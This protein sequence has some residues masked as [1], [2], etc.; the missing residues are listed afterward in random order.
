MS[1]AVR[2]LDRLGRLIAWFL[3]KPVRHYEPYAASNMETLRR[4]LM[5]GDVIL[6]DGDERL[7]VAIKYLTQSTWSHSVLYV[8]DAMGRSDDGSDPSTIVEVVLDGG[9][10]ASPLS[11]YARYNLRICRPIG[12]TPEDRQAVVSFMI[13]HIGIEY[14]TKNVIDL[15][16]YLLPTPPVPVRLRRRMLALGSGSPTRAICSTLIA[17]AFGSVRYPILPHVETVD[18]LGSGSSGYSRED[19]YHI[20]HHSLFA[21]RDFDLSPYFQVVK[22]TL[23]LGFDYKR[24]TWAEPE[25]SAA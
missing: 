1:L 24:L 15:M 22:P 4:I 8:G 2:V 19:I 14:D 5:P 20:R 3:Q 17:Q 18:A 7:S 9:C 10:K 13:A 6:V 23:Q 16:R 25:Q 12:L 11:K 21:P